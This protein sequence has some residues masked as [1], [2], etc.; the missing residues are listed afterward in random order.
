MHA[1]RCA[2]LSNSVG[3]PFW[4]SHGSL[5]S[6]FENYLADKFKTLSKRGR[7]YR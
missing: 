5:L 2:I 4:L 7:L 1:F 6:G 3:V